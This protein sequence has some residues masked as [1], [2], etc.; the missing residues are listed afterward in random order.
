MPK[1]TTDEEVIYSRD[2]GGHNIMNILTERVYC[3]RK[4]KDVEE[5]HK[6]EKSTAYCRRRKKGLGM[7]W[8]DLEKG[9]G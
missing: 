3:P 8:V 4:R 1:C 7:V 2:V 6:G 9:I 5:T